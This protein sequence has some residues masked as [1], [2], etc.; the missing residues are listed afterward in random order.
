MSV[1]LNSLK[2]GALMPATT[3]PASG[4]KTRLATSRPVGV[5][6]GICHVPIS[7]AA[8]AGVRGAEAAGLAVVAAGLA[9]DGAAGLAAAGAAGFAVD[10]SSALA[11]RAEP[12][13]TT[14]ASNRYV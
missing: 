10:W 7:G 12:L 14:V 11:A 8:S 2:F 5:S 13:V 4:R 9:V 3:L 6:S 1:I